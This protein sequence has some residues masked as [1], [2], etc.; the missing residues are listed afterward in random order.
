MLLLIR[1]TTTGKPLFKAEPGAVSYSYQLMYPEADRELADFID[2]RAIDT[3]M[4]RQKFEGGIS[5]SRAYWNIPDRATT[6][7]PAGLTRRVDSWVHKFCGLKKGE[8][9][10]IDHAKKGS[11]V[12]HRLLLE[13]TYARSKWCFGV[14]GWQSD[15]GVVLNYTAPCKALEQAGYEVNYSADSRGIV[16]SLG[17]RLRSYS[18]SWSQGSPELM[19]QG[20]QIAE[21]IRPHLLV[22]PNGKTGVVSSEELQRQQREYR[23]R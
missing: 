9:E 13:M 1:K 23:K 19:Q 6:K 7:D 17:V 22:H 3:Q 4:K 16:T 20:R 8:L 15:L 21:L 11:P 5:G 18:P 10:L 14:S 12:A 2:I